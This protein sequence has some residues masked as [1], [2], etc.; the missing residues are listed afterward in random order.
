M[1]NP[2][3]LIEI[4]RDGAEAIKYR[5]VEIQELFNNYPNAEYEHGRLIRE[6]AKSI[7]EALDQLEK[8]VASITDTAANKLK[9]QS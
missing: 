1:T 2:K 8:Q 5:G 9:E 6:E 3:E 7:L 4:V